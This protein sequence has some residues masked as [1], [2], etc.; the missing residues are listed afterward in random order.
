MALLYINEGTVDVL[1]FQTI[2]FFV[3]FNCQ[4]EALKH[5]NVKFFVQEIYFK[6]STSFYSHIKLQ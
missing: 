2:S 6:K 3:V 5:Y 4:L 1:C